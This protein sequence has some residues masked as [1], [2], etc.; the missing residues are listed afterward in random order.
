MAI[1]S[2]I[3][4]MVLELMAAHLTENLQTLIPVTDPIRA[5]KVKKGLLVENKTTDFIQ[6]GIQGGDHEAPDDEDGI[7]GLQK[8]PRIAM[9][10]PPREIGG[11]QVWMRRGVVRVEAFF[12]HKGI[13][14]DIAHQYGYALL[15]RVMRHIE[16]TPVFSLSPDDFGEQVATQ[17]YCYANT[18]FESGGPPSSFIFR[19]KVKW[20]LFTERP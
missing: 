19:G 6:L 13:T 1:P 4:N 7:V 12:L 16:T 20:A 15:G 11:G 10:I 14:E 2:Q 8:L 3:V 18:Y 17:V 9:D 5:H